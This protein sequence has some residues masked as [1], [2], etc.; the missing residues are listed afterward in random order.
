M[1]LL[2]NGSATA[3]IVTR[4]REVVSGVN[5]TFR[6][7]FWFPVTAP[8]GTVAHALPVQ[9]CTWKSLMPNELKVMLAVGS[10][11]ALYASCT[12]KTLTSLMVLT[13]LNATSSQSG[14]ASGVPSFHPPPLPHDWPLRSPLIAPTAAYPLLCVDDAV[15]VPP[16]AAAATF[17]QLAGGFTTTCTGADTVVPPP[18]S[19]ACAVNV[20]LPTPAVHVVELVGVKSPSSGGGAQIIPGDPAAAA[21]VLVEKL[22]NEARV[23]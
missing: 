2:P 9:Y 16:L 7:T 5:V 17:T 21:K 15:A 6:Q 23:L 1:R 18:L 8:P 12:L 10:T 11:G 13:P 4:M 14:H 22:R 3:W 20:W 19:Q